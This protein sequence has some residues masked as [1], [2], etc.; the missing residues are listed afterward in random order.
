MMKTTIERLDE[1][2]LQLDVE[3]PENVLQGAIDETLVMMGRELNLPGFRPGKVPPQAV[4]AR[5]GREAVISETIRVHL[6]DWYRAAVIGAGVRPVSQPEIE[7]PEG[8]SATPGVRFQAKVEVPAQPKLP[9][10][11]TLEVDKPNI[12][13]LQTY[14]DQVMEATLRGAGTLKDTGATAKQG[15]EV[16]VD[17]RCLVEG[18]EVSGAAATGYQARIG[19]GRLL[20]E[21]E[22]AILGTTAGTELEVPVTFPDDHPMEQ[23]AG[24]AATFALNVRSVQELELPEL[25]DEVAKQ[26]SE[27]QTAAE[28]TDN[29]TGSITER[30]EGEIS[31]IFRGNAVA[32][33][34]DA[35]ELAEPE[36]LVQGRQQ[37]LYAGLK[38]QLGQ[39]GLTVEQYLDRS[40]RD[41]ADL[42]AELEKSARDD[43][44]RELS[45]LA[46]AEQQGITVGEADLVQEITEHAQSTGQDVDSSVA[47]VFGSG[48]ADLLRGELLIQRAIDHLVATVKPRYIDMPTAEEAAAAAAANNEVPVVEPGSAADGDKIVVG[49]TA[50]EKTEA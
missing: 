29:I 10:L 50:A 1:T 13:G 26:V 46:L 33:L 39:S 7:F 49:E 19:D 4:M 34:A 15:D 30:L 28:L 32:A 11:S 35:A 38:Q 23:L 27:Y 24:K 2:T 5:L 16:V 41:S 22:E 17:F 31:G 44:R 47:Q 48:R 37:E 25:T 6:D 3:V 36:A 20:G 40:G 43:L 14:V 8:D 9:E 21:L 12:P 42:F 18:E 45:L